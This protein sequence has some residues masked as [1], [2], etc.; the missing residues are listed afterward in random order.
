[1]VNALIF[2]GMSKSWKNEQE[3]WIMIEMIISFQ[4]TIYEWTGLETNVFS[5]IIIH[6]I[7]M[8]KKRGNFKANKT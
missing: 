7:N 4:T 5:C 1:M 3:N 2:K 8:M 6:A